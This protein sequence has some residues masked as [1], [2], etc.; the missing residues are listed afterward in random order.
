MFTYLLYL[1]KNFFKGIS[2]RTS[3]SLRDR[4]KRF[5]KNLTKEN[6]DT[7]ITWI[8]KRDSAQGYFNFIGIYN[9]FIMANNKIL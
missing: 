5:L 1:K 4:F 6:L 7:T 9:F 2:N 3:E 8:Q